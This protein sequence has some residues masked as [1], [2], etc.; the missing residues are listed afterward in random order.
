MSDTSLALL[1]KLSSTNPDSPRKQDEPEKVTTEL[2]HHSESNN[3]QLSDKEALP[4]S[5]IYS[6]PSQLPQQ[7]EI[8]DKAVIS[9]APSS[10]K[11]G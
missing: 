11:P 10:M 8:S 6:Q 5:T 2:P 9:A 3:A 1:G 4:A 7:A